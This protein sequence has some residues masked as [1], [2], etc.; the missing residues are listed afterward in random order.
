MPSSSATL[1][2]R[3]PLIPKQIRDAGIKTPLIGLTASFD[4]TTYPKMGDELIGG[5][6]ASLYSAA[7]ET[8][9]N[10]NFVNGYRAKY[11]EDPS[12]FSESGYTAMMW[13]DKAITSLHGDVH[14]KEKLLAA[15]EKVELKDA[16]RGP[17]KLDA[18]DSSI[19]NVYVSR[20][21]SKNG[22]K[23][24]TVIYTYPLVSEFWKYSPAKYLKQPSY[25]KDYP[26]CKYCTPKH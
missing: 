13:I 9:A 3:G 5:V 15:L 18:F 6:C 24:N 16:P 8:P 1:A 17:V 23:R 4:E 2:N 22:K 20:V 21:E 7:L 25:T 14:D 10:H 19:D 11:G 26:P 12:Y